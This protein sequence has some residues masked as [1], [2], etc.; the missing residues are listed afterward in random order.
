MLWIERMKVKNPWYNCNS[1]LT[2]ELGIEDTL[3]AAWMDWS[4][5][6]C[7]HTNGPLWRRRQTGSWS[8]PGEGTARF[9]CSRIDTQVCFRTRKKSKRQIRLTSVVRFFESVVI[10]RFLFCCWFWIWPWARKKCSMSA[11]SP[12][13]NFRRP[14]GPECF[15]AVDALQQLHGRVE[16]KL[17]SNVLDSLVRTILS[18]NTTDKTSI[19]AF[20]SLKK[21]SEFP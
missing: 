11:E 1:M 9:F 3:S 18:Q 4:V 21:V 5:E 19:R 17:G 14:T 20:R 8:E 7:E 6:D 12:F 16:R 13:P 10:H 2:L 15:A